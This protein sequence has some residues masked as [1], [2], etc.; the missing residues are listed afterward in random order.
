VSITS[1]FSLRIFVAD[2]DPDGLR[3]VE[4]S[5]WIGKAI[6]F[7]RALLPS[8]KQRSE[9][10]QTG[11]YLLL[12]PREDGEGEMLYVGEG[13]PIKPRLESHYAQKDFWTRAVCFV[14]GQGQLN[15]AHVQYLEAALIR[16]AKV[17]KR[18]PLDNANQPADPSLS[19]ADLADLNVFLG[20]MLGMLPVLGINA[21][22][23]AQSKAQAGAVT[24]LSAKGKGVSAQGF[25]S[26]QGFVV[27]AG[28]EAVAETAPS[29]EQY[30][31][32]MYELRQQLIGNGVLA[33]QGDR[34]LFTQDYVF[35]SPSTAAAVVLGRS[36]NGRVEW[37]DKTGRTLKELQTQEA[38]T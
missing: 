20:N 37:K 7:P 14:A 35:S 21:F 19:E 34:Y 11:V 28:S 38:G 5:N 9:F 3:L 18:L 23:V 1:P 13:D 16:R 26:T 36:A 8:I 29:M 6:M 31:H 15:K 33:A 27:K 30:V 25:E 12:G 22:E 17:A 2:G 10:A 32:G 4:R 24:I